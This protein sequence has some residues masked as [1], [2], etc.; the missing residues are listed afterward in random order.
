[1]DKLKEMVGSVCDNT[2]NLPDPTIIAGRINNRYEGVRV[3]GNDVANFLESEYH[4][5]E[6]VNK[7]INRHRGFNGEFY[8]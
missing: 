2:T 8:V 6:Y 5:Q 1:M 3:S 4:E 7:L